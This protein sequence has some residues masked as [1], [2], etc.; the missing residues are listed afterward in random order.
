MYYCVYV[1]IY[2]RNKQLVHDLDCSGMVNWVVCIPNRLGVPRR[3]YFNY[4]LNT[5]HTN[6]VLVYMRACV[7]LY[8]IFYT[9]TLLL[10]ILRIY[11]FYLKEV[12]SWCTTSTA[13]EW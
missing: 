9:H 13:P 3:L 5:T 1:E 2:E 8:Y 12:N 11:C 7:C 10:C 6:N 4:M